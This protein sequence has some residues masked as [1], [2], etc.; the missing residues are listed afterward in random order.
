MKY[1]VS[2]TVNRFEMDADSES[3]AKQNVIALLNSTL[4]S[5]VQ[6]TAF[7][8]LE[9]LRALS[10]PV[11]SNASK[12]KVADGTEI[13]MGAFQTIK[14]EKGEKNPGAAKLAGLDPDEDR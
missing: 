1:A 11:R 13:L 14:H 12:D 9:G 5:S 6:V 7:G 10:N 3:Q 4:A 2:I 8:E